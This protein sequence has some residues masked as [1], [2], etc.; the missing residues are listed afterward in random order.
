MS[1]L[2]TRIFG[3]VIVRLM[4]APELRGTVSQ[5]LGHA[6]LNGFGTDP[7]LLGDLT[8]GQTPTLLSTKTS[9]RGCGNLSTI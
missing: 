7:E 2:S 8:V 3:L 9:R 6:P 5:G 1:A 4:L